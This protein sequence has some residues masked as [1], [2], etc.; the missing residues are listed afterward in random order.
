MRTTRSRLATLGFVV[1]AACG[2]SRSSTTDDTTTPPPATPTELATP[3][4]PATPT[5]AE[6]ATPPTP[7]V[8]TTDPETAPPPVA[9]KVLVLVDDKGVGLGGHDP[10]AYATA[11]KPV[12][13]SATHTA[14]HAGATYRFASAENKTKFESDAAKHAPRYGGYC[15]YAASQNRLSKSDPKVFLIHDG[16]LLVFTSRDFLAR[17]QKDPA[18]HKQK[19]DASWPGLVEKHGKAP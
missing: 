12:P 9:A 5:T 1:L 6:P 17:F 8:P 10:V 19:A 4:E 15:A 14:T 11:S 13:G 18:G 2:G 7:A 3:T 16:D